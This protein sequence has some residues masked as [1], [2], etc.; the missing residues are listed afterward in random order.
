MDCQ[1]VRSTLSAFQDGHVVEAER[2]LVATHLARCADCSLLQGEMGMVRQSVRALAPKTLPAHD[3]FALRALASREA[4]HR[5]RVHT[6][7][8]WAGDMVDRVR[9]HI[10]NLMRPLALP[11]A[12]GLASAVFLFSMVMGNLQRIERQ[13]PND[14]RIA[15]QTEPTLRASL[16]DIAEAELSVDVLVDEQGRVIDFALPEGYGAASTAHLRRKLENFLLFT[17]FNPATTFGHPTSGWVRMKFKRSAI[18]VQG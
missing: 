16:L 11:A 2:R 8:A 14:V 9:L 1:Q 5:R 12:G 3:Q 10:H 17:E 13:H 15:I 7:E 4:A 6:F 18:D